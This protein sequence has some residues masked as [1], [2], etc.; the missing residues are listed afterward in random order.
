MNKNTYELGEITSGTK[1]KEELSKLSKYINERSPL[2]SRKDMDDE[3]RRSV[4]YVLNHL[5][6]IASAVNIGYLSERYLYV[7]SHSMVCLIY[8]VSM[9]YILEMRSLRG[10]KTF[11]RNFEMLYVRYFFRSK[12]SFIRIPELIIGEKLFTASYFEFRLHYVFISYIF[13]LPKKYTDND[14]YKLKRIYHY[15]KWGMRAIILYIAF[16]YYIAYGV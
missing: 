14:Q 5:E 1:L 9:N 7:T 11:Y 13:D 4:S 10:A 16:L 15:Y 3:T 8:I 12:S 2:P 6:Y